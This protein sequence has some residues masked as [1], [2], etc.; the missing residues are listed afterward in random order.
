MVKCQQNQVLLVVDQQKFRILF[1]LEISSRWSSGEIEQLCLWLQ[2]VILF[3]N[4]R[5]H[6]IY[7][8]SNWILDKGTFYEQQLYLT[9]ISR[10]G[11]S[12]IDKN[13]AKIGTLVSI[14]RYNSTTLLEE[15]SRAVISLHLHI[16]TALQ[17]MK[18]WV[19]NPVWR[20]M[21]LAI[22][23]FGHEWRSGCHGSWLQSSCTLVV[24]C[25]RSELRGRNKK[26]CIGFCH[27]QFDFVLGHW[28]KSTA[29]SC[30]LHLHFHTWLPLCLLSTGV[31]SSS[32]FFASPFRWCRPLKEKPQRCRASLT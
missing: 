2:F 4:Q 16:Q 17:V 22:P 9:K 18:S 32:H 3:S 5:K 14:G 20:G 30:D 1:I 19:E 15:Y 27:T 8:N 7:Q 23:W 24:L 29:S 25:F 31:L 13:S 21:A 12:A 6:R 26:P 11:K 10:S 28:M